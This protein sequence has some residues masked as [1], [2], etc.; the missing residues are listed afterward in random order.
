[1][2]E[3]R[4]T[5]LAF[6]NFCCANVLR[7][8]TRHKVKEREGH[9][10]NKCRFQHAHEADPMRVSLSGHTVEWRRMERGPGTVQ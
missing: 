10:M 3:G 9:L 1:M 6:V 7:V 2:G 8:V 4:G 5:Y